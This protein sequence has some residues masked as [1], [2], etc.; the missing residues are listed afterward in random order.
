MKIRVRHNKTE[1]VRWIDEEKRHLFARN[2]YI[3]EPEPKAPPPPKKA[4]KAETPKAEAPKEEKTKQ[5]RAKK[6]KK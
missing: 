1:N 3:E 4:P 5:T 6:R 2:G